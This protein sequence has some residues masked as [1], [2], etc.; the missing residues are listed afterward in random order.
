[1]RLRLR[2][3]GVGF[4][5]SLVAVGRV[6]PH[7]RGNRVSY[8]HPG[9]TEWYA[10]GPLGLEQGFTVARPKLGG[11]G[12]LR[13]SLAVSG[14]LRASLADQ[15]RAVNLEHDGRAVLAY[16]NLVASDARGRA[17]PAR[18]VLDGNRLEIRVDAR[19]AAY[20]VTIDPLIQQ[21][22]LT[23][24]DPAFAEVGTSVAVSSDGST[25]VAGAPYKGSGAVYVFVK[26]A[27]GGRPRRR[28]PRS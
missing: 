16:R 5:G 9:V 28:R 1:M 14:D 22:T 27:A 7:A 19:E 6:A 20:P 18:L 2:L 4:G 3:A 8:V 23:A 24:S 21:A 15:G 13:L 25:V 11:T 12:A 17:L 26:P 10:N